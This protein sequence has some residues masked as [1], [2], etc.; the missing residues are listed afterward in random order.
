MERTMY[1]IGQLMGNRLALPV[2]NRSR[3]EIRSRFNEYN[4]R[5]CTNFMFSK[6]VP[7]ESAEI[8]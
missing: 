3:I 6:I 4:K 7:L 8:A 1:V 5:Y 2:F